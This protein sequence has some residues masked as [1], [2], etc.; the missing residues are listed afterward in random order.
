MYEPKKDEIEETEKDYDYE[1]D[2]ELYRDAQEATWI[3]YLGL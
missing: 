2:D 3:E 1:W